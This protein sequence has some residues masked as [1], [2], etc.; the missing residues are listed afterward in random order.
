MNALRLQIGKAKAVD[1]TFIK[2]SILRK[3]TKTDGYR[4]RYA[5]TGIGLW[6]PE[7]IRASSSAPGMV[8]AS[9]RLSGATQSNSGSLTAALLT[10]FVQSLTSP[11]QALLR[12]TQASLAS[13]T[14]WSVLQSLVSQ[15]I[16]APAI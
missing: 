3:P 11:A 5:R 4:I 10:S 1:Q 2:R 6:P 9:A 16:S 7:M 14:N 13:F 8:I 15:D 12:P